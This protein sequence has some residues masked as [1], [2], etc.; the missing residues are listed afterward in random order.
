ML[1][2]FHVLAAVHFLI[3]MVFVIY[4][5]LVQDHDRISVHSLSRVLANTVPD[6]NM[7]I[8]IQKYFTL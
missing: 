8:A 6:K 2:L 5:M 7:L 3:Y 1:T 4:R